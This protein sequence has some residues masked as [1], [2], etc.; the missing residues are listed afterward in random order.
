MALL[1]VAKTWKQPKCPL[2]EEWVKKWYI[3]TMEYCSATKKKEM[4]PFAATW[5]D[6]ETVI[7]SG[8]SQRRRNSI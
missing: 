3:Y 4:K 1:T 5:M 6:A 8:V 2:K 7:L